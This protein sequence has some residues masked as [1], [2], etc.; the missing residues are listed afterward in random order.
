MP[1]K[2]NKERDGGVA[3]GATKIHYTSALWQKCDLRNSLEADSSV[4]VHG[5][6]CVLHFKESTTRQKN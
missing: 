3:N 4:S 1:F 6:V 2:D 5:D